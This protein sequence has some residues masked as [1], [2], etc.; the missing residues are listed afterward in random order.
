M[1][2]IKIAYGLRVRHAMGGDVEAIN[3]GQIAPG[4]GPGLIFSPWSVH[5]TAAVR[6]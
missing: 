5:E 1:G 2:I 6:W 4:I 3:C